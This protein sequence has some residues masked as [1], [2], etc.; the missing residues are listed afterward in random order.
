MKTYNAGIAPIVVVLI[1]LG[2]IVAGGAV[3]FATKSSTEVAIESTSP[4]MSPASTTAA[5]KASQTV[6]PTAVRTATPTPSKAATVGTYAT[7]QAAWNAGKPVECVNAFVAEKGPET[8]VRYILAGGKLRQ[9]IEVKNSA[10]AVGVS[11]TTIY[12]PGT[13]IYTFR[14]D[15][16]VTTYKPG[17]NF[18]NQYSKAYPGISLTSFTCTDTAVH[19][20]TFVPPGMAN[21]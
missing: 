9:Q 3:Y 7:I 17:E 10:G 6:H 1:V 12:V 19:S 8:R 20:S 11:S 4:S 13:A 5:P 14:S 2:I 18:Y 21:Y 16:V 15:N